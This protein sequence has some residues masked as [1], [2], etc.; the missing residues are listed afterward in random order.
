MKITI[1]ALLTLIISTNVQAQPVGDIEAEVADVE[2]AFAKTM[3]DRDLAAFS[4]FLADDTVF[5][6]GDAALR[7]KQAVI[8]A[9]KG[10]YDGAE[11][12]FKWKPEIVMANEGGRLALSTGPVSNDD[13]IYSYYTSIWRKNDD[14]SWHII[15][16][17]GQKYCETCAE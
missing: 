16:D 6:N 3:A 1:L 11:A 15:F 10:F 12:P 9:W 7:G 5:W 8:E 13:G 14:G 17:K 2:R 4:S